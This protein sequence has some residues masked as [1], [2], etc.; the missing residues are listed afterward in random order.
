[1]AFQDFTAATT[2][3]SA[4]H[5]CARQT[6][7]PL[8]CGRQYALHRTT[9]AAV[10]P[11]PGTPEVLRNQSDVCYL[12]GGEL[13]CNAGESRFSL[14]NVSSFRV[15]EDTVCALLRDG[16][17]QCSAANLDQWK[18]GP[19]S[20]LYVVPQVIRLNEPLDR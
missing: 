1:V 11:D 7:G 2:F 5:L 13:Q 3:G 14:S 15:S 17:V 9:D 12:Q 6:T 4:G 8:R 20:Y 19:A 16:S 10:L 18:V